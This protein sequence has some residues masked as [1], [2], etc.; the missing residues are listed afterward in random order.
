MVRGPQFQT[1]IKCVLR[2]VNI[3]IVKRSDAAKGFIVL[4]G[5]VDEVLTLAEIKDQTGPPYRAFVCQTLNPWGF[6]AKDRSGRLDLMEEPHLGRL[7]EKIRGPARSPADR[8]V[9]GRPAASALPPTDTQ[10]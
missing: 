8:L 10:S 1:A 2:H 4:P 7:F 3:E 5:I 6:P 9:F